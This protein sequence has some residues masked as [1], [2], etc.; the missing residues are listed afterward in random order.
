MRRTLTIVLAFA[1]GVAVA[2]DL[3]RWVDADGKVHFG[4][5]P[6]A[7]VK[8][9]K[10]GIRSQPTD[11]AAL[12][13]EEATNTEQQRVTAEVERLKHYEALT[14]QEA[15]DAKAA[16]C[17]AAQKHLAEIRDERKVA[18][19]GADGEETWARGDDAIKLKEKAAADVKE[20]CGD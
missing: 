5:S 16:D 12:A 19:T 15:A 7:G 17:A 4:D 11:P 20:K 9:E 6:P 3:Y 18:V 14:A 8:A 10:L 1:A 2:G 13:R